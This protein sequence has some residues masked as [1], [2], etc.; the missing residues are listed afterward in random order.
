MN[1]DNQARELVQ[2]LRDAVNVLMDAGAFATSGMYRKA[3]ATRNK[4]DAYLAT[5]AGSTE[6][7][8]DAERLAR[9]C[10]TYSAAL[11]GYGSRL[12]NKSAHE[13]AMQAVL[14]EL[15]ASRPPAKEAD[16]D[17]PVAIMEC[18]AMGR[19]CFTALDAAYGLSGKYELYIHPAATAPGEGSVSDA[20]RML[21][22]ACEAEFECDAR[23]EEGTLLFTDEDKVSFPEDECNITFGHIRKARAALESFAKRRAAKG[24]SHE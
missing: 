2:E 3:I 22:E 5:P 6:R 21:V 8:S 9:A 14:A 17:A 13:V 18:R 11:N 4:A 7:P 12:Q 19:P 20:L 23:D 24:G 10:A 15:D 1:N 16:S